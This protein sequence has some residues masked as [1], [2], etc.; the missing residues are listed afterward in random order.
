MT[1]STQ[2]DIGYYNYCGGA[3][4]RHRPRCLDRCSPQHEG[5]ETKLSHQKTAKHRTNLSLDQKQMHT[6]SLVSCRGVVCYR[7]VLCRRYLEYCCEV[8]V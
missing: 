4:F 1:D 3:V 7:V 5:P 8:I 2:S 6:T